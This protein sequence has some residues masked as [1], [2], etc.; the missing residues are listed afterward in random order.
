MKHEKA[1]TTPRFEGG[2]GYPLYLCFGK[3]QIIAFSTNFRW[4]KVSHLKAHLHTTTFYL[5]LF[6]CLYDHPLQRNSLKTLMTTAASGQLGRNR[7]FSV[8][9][10]VQNCQ[11][12]HPH[13]KTFHMSLF[14][15]LYYYVSKNRCFWTIWPNSANSG[16]RFWPKG[17]STRQDLSYEPIPRSLRPS[18]TKIQSGKESM[19]DRLGVRIICGNM[20]ILAFWGQRSRYVLYAGAYTINYK[21]RIT[22]HSFL[23]CR[24]VNLYETKTH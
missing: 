13:T 6:I 2:I 8:A 3:S 22:V 19:T 15:G 5:N 23:R 17:T 16:G 10:S 1:P 24:M 9:D 4:P 14:S 21:R 20:N 18:V 7:P 12:A 11:K